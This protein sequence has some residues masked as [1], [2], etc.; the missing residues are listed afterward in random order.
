MNRM[1]LT[2][3]ALTLTAGTAAADSST[4]TA[5]LKDA[6]GKPTGTATFTATGGIVQLKLKATGLSPGKHGIHVHE[7]GRCDGDFKSAGAHYNPHGKKHGG[8]NDDGAHAGDLPNL[9]ADA[10]G[11]AALQTTLHGVTLD[12][13]AANSLLDKDGAALVIHAKEDDERSDPAG[14]SGDRI[15]CGVITRAP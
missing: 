10:D 1:I 4:A 6:Q 5:A 11:K 3:A 8:Q 7:V 15:A 12:E 13:G 2:L 14:N 9:T